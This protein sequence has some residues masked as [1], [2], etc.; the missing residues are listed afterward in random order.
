MILDKYRLDGKVAIIT[1]GSRGIGR[2]I[3][4]G[5]A[6]AGSDVIVSSRKL[7]DLQKVADEIS[8]L[9][10]RSLAV[11]AHAAR[12]EEIDNLLK[13]VMDEF[14]RIDILV[15]NAGANPVYGS[16]IEIE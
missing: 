14:G 8:A 12:K 3:A 7:P 16:L 10:R 6:E 4:L 5:F 11:A 1:G 13:I 15:N 9:G 2:A